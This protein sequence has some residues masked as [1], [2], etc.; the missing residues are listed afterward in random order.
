MAKVVTEP[1]A[2][3]AASWP[4]QYFL[5]LTWSNQLVAASSIRKRKILFAYLRDLAQRLPVTGKSGRILSNRKSFEALEWLSRGELGETTGRHHLHVLLAG[6]S[7]SCLNKSTTFFIKNRW[8]TVTGGSHARVWRYDASLPG[9]AYVLKPC[10]TGFDKNEAISYEIAKFSGDDGTCEL[11]LAHALLEKWGARRRN[12]RS[13]GTR[14][15]AV[16]GRRSKDRS[17]TGTKGTGLV[18]SFSLSSAQR[19]PA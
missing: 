3:E 6:L 19:G 2:W 14:A 17:G 16:C 5:T 11:M 18:S 8:E 7:P 10:P 15:A 1:I 12:K 13:Q 9:A 4:W